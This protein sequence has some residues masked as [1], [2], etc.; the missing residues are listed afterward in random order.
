MLDLPGRGA[1][2]PGVVELRDG[3]ILMI[4]RSQLGRIYKAYSGDG[5]V[6]WSDPQETAIRAPESPATIKRIPTTQDLLL[7]WN[8]HYDP[9]E[10]MYG[11]RSPLVAA[12][13]RD[14]GERWEDRRELEKDS[15]YTYAYVSVAF[16]DD[17][18]VLT[19]YQGLAEDGLWSLKLKIVPVEWFYSKSSA[20][21]S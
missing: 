9:Y 2:E 6:T 19:Y 3:R 14:E 21:P 20:Q 11:R 12:I 7:V 18:T 10:P 16:S 5:G 1:M 13:S 17:R 8:D 15:E 4:I